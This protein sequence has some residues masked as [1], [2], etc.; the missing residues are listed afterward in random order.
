MGPCRIGIQLYPQ[1]TTVAALR[2]A[3]READDLG[4]D[5]IWTWDHFFGFS[6][7]WT[8]LRAGAHFESWSLLAAMAADTSRAEL[9]TLVTCTSYRSP[10]L[11]ADIART[12][13]HISGGRV[14]LGIGAGYSEHEHRQ[15]GLPYLPTAAARLARFE[16]DIATIKARLARLEPPPMGAMPILIGGIGERITLRLVAE[17]ASAWNMVTAKQPDPVAAFRHKNGV[18][19]HW[20]ERIGRDPASVER[21][22]GVGHD[23]MHLVEPL[24]EA[25]ANHIILG[26]PDP[27]DLSDLQQLLQRREDATG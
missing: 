2:R 23:E 18:L 5:S 10:D 9:G 8:H 24:I 6:P 27:F 15:Y 16:T 19:T 22:V 4:V 13:D 7:E 3:W 17:H 26:C 25:G 11:L 21:S 1:F 12:V 20:C 14:V